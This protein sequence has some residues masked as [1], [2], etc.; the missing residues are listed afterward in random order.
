VN[1]E[2]PANLISY[3]SGKGEVLTPEVVKND[4]AEIKRKYI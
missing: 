3:A 4:L 1:W 2:I